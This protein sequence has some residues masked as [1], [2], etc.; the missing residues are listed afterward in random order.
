MYMRLSVNRLAPEH[1]DEY[2]RVLQE[3]ATAVNQAEPHCLNYHVLLGDPDDDVLVIYEVFENRD[4]FQEHI[5]SPHYEDFTKRVKAF[6][7]PITE[8]ILKLE[9]RSLVP[10]NAEW[11]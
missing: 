1:R 4:A 3:E 5:T 2:L 11:R 9:A 8:R 6:G 7:G 10:S